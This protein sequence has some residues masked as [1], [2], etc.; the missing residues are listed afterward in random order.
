[1]SSVLA[2]LQYGWRLIARNKGF[3]TVAILTLALGIGANTATFSVFKAVVLTPFPYPDARDI[4][5]LSTYMRQD[6]DSV[7]VSYPISWTGSART[8]VF[9][10]LG[11][12]RDEA[13]GLTDSG[14][15]PYER[16]GRHGLGQRVPTAWHR[17]T[18][19]AG[20]PGGRRP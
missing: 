3:G 6:E 13:F 7:Q 14:R 16:E 18:R 19:R 5:W 17:A 1:M 10:Q 12:V 15:E 4:M 20:L 8:A 9:A 2:D 11:A